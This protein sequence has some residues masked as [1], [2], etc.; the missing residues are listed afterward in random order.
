MTML[1]Q[2]LA[3]CLRQCRAALET[4]LAE[5]SDET[6]RRVISRRIASAERV[7]AKVPGAMA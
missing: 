1:E 2:E 7:L 4:V 6:A 3:E 5:T